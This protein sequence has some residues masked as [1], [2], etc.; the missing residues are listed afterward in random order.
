[1]SAFRAARSADRWRNVPRDMARAHLLDPAG[2]RP[3]GGGA[4]PPTLATSQ[5][6]DS[7]PSFMLFIFLAFSSPCP[8]S[9]WS[10]PATWSRH[11]Q[12]THCYKQVIKTPADTISAVPPSSPRAADRWR[13]APRDMGRAYVIDPAGKDRGRWVA[14]GEL[15]RRPE[16]R[17]PASAHAAVWKPWVVCV[18]CSVGR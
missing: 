8:R 13:N 1:L 9:A 6:F 11:G 7:P 3:G 16:F 12:L 14:G 2:K 15:C 18:G 10:M 17:P 5:K 4:Y